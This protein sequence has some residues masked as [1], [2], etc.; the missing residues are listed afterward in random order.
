MK[1]KICVD[2]SSNLV[3]SY[4]NDEKIGFKVIPLTIRVGKKEFV[5]DDNLNVASMLKEVEETKEQCS[6]SCPSPSDFLENYQN[7]EHV[8]CIT[9]S[10]KLSGS[11]N[12]ACVAR[13]MSENKDN[14]FVIDSKLTAGAMRL[15]VDKAYELCKKDID[16]DEIKAELTK[17]RDS[18]QL[19]FVLDKFDNLVRNGRMSKVTAF[20]AQLAAIKP[21]CYG[22][23]GEIK[24]KEKIRTFKGVLKRLVHNIGVMCPVTK[25][26]TCVISHT[27]NKESALFLK[28]LIEQEY[29]FDKI[30]LDDNRGLCSFYAL[31]GGLIVSF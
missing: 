11:F 8:I 2:S 12:S 1:Y 18:I 15:L 28:N 29:E 10:K 21:L 31:R 22:D 13:D 26:R 19:L 20:I 16:F 27:D 17:Y 24:I 9:I 23:D 7:A 6:S 3:N 14:I 5:D 4:I 30:I 25:G